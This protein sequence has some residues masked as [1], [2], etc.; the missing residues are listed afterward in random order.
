MLEKVAVLVLPDIAMFELGISAELFSIDRTDTGG[1]RFDFTLCSTTAGPVRTE[2]GLDLQVAAGLE[3]TLNADLIVVTP[4]SSSDVAPEPVLEALRAAHQRGAWLLSICS[5]AFVLAA[6]GLLDGRRCTTHWMHSDELAARYPRAIV[7]PSVLYVEQDRIITSAGSAAGIDAGLHLIRK[8]L[9]AQVAANIARRM[10]V[11]PHRDGGQAQFIE[12]PILACDADSLTE[13][14]E[15]MAVNVHLDQ[16]VDEL[17]AHALMSPRTFARRFR[18]ETGTTPAVWVAQQRLQR[19]RELLETTNLSIDRIAELTG[20]GSAP[21]LR[22]HFTRDM[23][24]TP[25]AYRR[26]FSCVDVEPVT[27]LEVAG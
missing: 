6:A 13:V 1:G 14:L 9:G 20:F 24:V 3:A 22:H 19:T 23:G 16:S 27:D 11:P 26:R 12:R 17:A 18:A 2:L 25:Q 4:I 15:W 10:V 7:D 8:E 21:V 5:G